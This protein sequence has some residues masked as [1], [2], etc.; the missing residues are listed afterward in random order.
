MR[1]IGDGH[2][3]IGKGLIVKARAS[4]LED[5]DDTMASQRPLDSI[6][7][8]TIGGMFTMHA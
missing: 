1:D 6:L 5:F 3:N 4:S 8:F 2:W 7:T